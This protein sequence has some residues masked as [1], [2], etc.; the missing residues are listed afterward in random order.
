VSNA[1]NSLS[2]NN[3][4]SIGTPVNIKLY[5]SNA[6]VALVTVMSYYIG[7]PFRFTTSAGASY[8]GTFEA[9]GRVDF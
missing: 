4:D 3:I 5:V 2:Y 7:Q 1:G 8:Q 9:D 6:Q